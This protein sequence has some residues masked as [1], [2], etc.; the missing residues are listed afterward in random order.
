MLTSMNQLFA[1]TPG[2]SLQPF[3]QLNVSGEANVVLIPSQQSGYSVEPQEK[4]ASVSVVQNGAELQISNGA[5]KVE[6]LL[7]GPLP[8]RI[9]VRGAGDVSTRGEF[10]AGSVE[11]M[12]SGAGD[13]SLSGNFDSI[14]AT[15]SGAGDLYMKGQAKLLDAMVSGAGDL[16]AKDLDAQTAKVT[17][18]GAGDA[19]V[20]AIASMDAAVSG[21]GSIV[22]SGDPQDR[23]VR[24]TGTGSVRQTGKGNVLVDEEVGV[25]R[26]SDSKEDTTSIR[27]GGK[28]IIIVEDYE[29]NKVE[30]EIEIEPSPDASGDSSVEPE[31]PAKPK[32]KDIWSGFEIGLNGYYRDAFKSFAIPQKEYELD[33]PRSINL[34]LNLFEQHLRLYKNY[35]ALTT[36]LG[37]SFNRY[38]FDRDISLTSDTEILDTLMT[39]IGYRKNMLKASYL[40]V[41]L[42]LQVATHSNPKKAFHIGAGI[43]GGLRLGSRTKQIWDDEGKQKKVIKDSYNLNPFR[44]SLMLRVGYGKFNV[45]AEYGLSEMFRNGRGPELYPFSAGVTLI[46]F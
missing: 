25:N 5:D 12:V 16:V 40:T 2:V 10:P 1:Q 27:I 11:V 13:L 7:F 21:V 42:F 22:Y 23:K 18:S 4:M 41:P 43:V 36:G 37:F 3:T 29:G 38:M 28:K 15:V 26:D 34:N 45:Y 9:N 39:G 30:R 35:L 32:V 44:Y 31:L 24:I 6:V 19:R 17:V 33:Y 8:S 20:H 46:P 14:S